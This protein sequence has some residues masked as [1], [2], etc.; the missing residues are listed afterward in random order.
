MT[1][2]MRR[3]VRAKSKVAHVNR[4]FRYHGKGSYTWRNLREPAAAEDAREVHAQDEAA[5]NRNHLD[6]ADAGAEVENVPALLDVPETSREV[7]EEE[8]P[9]E[10]DTQPADDRGRKLKRSS[11]HKYYYVFD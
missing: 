9:E 5:D 2:R 8:E 4:L 3:S 10:A 11:R 7:D 1:Y 6:T